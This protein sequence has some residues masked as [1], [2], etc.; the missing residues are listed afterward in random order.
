MKII[1]FFNLKEGVSAADYENWA[2]RTDPPTIKKMRSI[3]DF[4]TNRATGLLGKDSPSPYY[5]VEVIEVNDIDLLREEMLS[6]NL[7]RVS[8][9][10]R[11]YVDNPLFILTEK[12]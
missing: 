12:I 1:A 9:E 3:D 11:K 8:E 7:R 6:E 2:R 5:Y 10:F 4:S